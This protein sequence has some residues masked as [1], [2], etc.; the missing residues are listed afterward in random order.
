[1]KHIYGVLCHEDSKVLEMF[2]KMSKENEI[3]MHIDKKSDL[4]KFNKYNLGNVT[5]V[6][7]RMYSKWGNIG[8]IKA[9]LNILKEANLRDF[10]YI[11]IV[12][13]Q[14]LLIKSK[15][16][17]EDILK[18]NN[19]KEFIGIDKNPKMSELDD[20]VKYEYPELFYK[21]KEK[22]YLLKIKKRIQVKL[23]LFKKNINY[24]KLPKL[25]RGCN[26]FTLSKE[27][28]KYICEYVEQNPEFLEAFEKSFCSD[29][30]FFQTIIMN[31]KFKENIY[32]L[33]E[34]C[35]ETKMALRYI[36]W[37]SGPEYPRILKNEDLEKLKNSEC[38][39]ARKFDKNLDIELFE[40]IL[41]LQNKKDL[42]R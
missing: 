24:D 7:N 6:K 37:E 11:S 20:R 13:G 4:D 19:G 30:I 3:I 25:Y 15:E 35:H 29:E 40:K 23:K 21:S 36:D 18:K 26:W 22:N 32:K 39:I 17:I 42:E 1:M 27:C 8:F 31:S 33:N 2:M 10:D 38:I 5:F 34:E 28:V 12:S 9:T 14:C 41:F 16:E